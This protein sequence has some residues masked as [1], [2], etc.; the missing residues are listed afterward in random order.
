[1]PNFSAKG[2]YSRYSDKDNSKRR[3]TVNTTQMTRARMMTRTKTIT[4]MIASREILEVTEILLMERHFRSQ[5]AVS[6][7]IWEV[8]QMPN[9]RLSPG[10]TM[11]V[12]SRTGSLSY[13]RQPMLIV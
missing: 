1:M 12:L 5:K 8:M 3:T 10:M 7:E 2:N 11:Q 4:L 9:A 6:M 13:I